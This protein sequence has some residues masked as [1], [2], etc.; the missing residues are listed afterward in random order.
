MRCGCAAGRGP[1]GLRLET[2]RFYI[3]RATYVVPNMRLL[4]TKAVTVLAQQLVQLR[5]QSCAA[6][7]MKY[8]ALAEYQ[9]ALDRRAIDWNASARHRRGCLPRNIGSSAT[10]VVLVIDAGSRR[11]SSPSARCR[12]STARIGGAAAKQFYE[13][14]KLGDFDQ[15]LLCR[16]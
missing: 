1:L 8:E 6:K 12:A 9:L 14:L 7:A 4:P 3:D 11:W 10:T 5:Q 15:S 2:A 13:G 16:C